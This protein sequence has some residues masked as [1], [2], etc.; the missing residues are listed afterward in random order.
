MSEAA[1]NRRA[2]QRIF[3]VATAGMLLLLFDFFVGF[4]TASLQLMKGG[5]GLY[6]IRP[7][8]GSSAGHIRLK[9]DIETDTGT[10][11][12]SYD[13]RLYLMPRQTTAATFPAGAQTNPARRPASCP[14]RNLSPTKC[15]ASSVP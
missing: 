8:A 4:D 6:L 12:K 10:V 13:L 15:A 1:L 3:V 14:R 2:I 5:N 7:A 9:A 11:S